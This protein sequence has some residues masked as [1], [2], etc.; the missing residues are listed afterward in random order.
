MK[1]DEKYKITLT[2]IR[3]TCVCVCVCDIGKSTYCSISHV[4]VYIYISIWIVVFVGMCIIQRIERNPR[5][6]GR[7][8]CYYIYRRRVGMINRI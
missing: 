1:I 6:N 5:T 4:R 2:I 3:R 8:Y 7:Q